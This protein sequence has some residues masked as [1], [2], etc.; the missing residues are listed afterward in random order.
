MK[1]HYLRRSI[2]H[3]DKISYGWKKKISHQNLSICVLNSKLAMF[4]NNAGKR[5]LY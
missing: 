5:N 2:H 3:R 1:Q 4:R